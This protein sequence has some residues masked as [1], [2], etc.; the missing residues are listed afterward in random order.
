MNNRKKAG[1]CI[2]ALCL[3]LGLAM[4]G[5]TG[6][7]AEAPETAAAESE[8]LTEAS[9]TVTGKSEASADVVRVMVMNGPTGFGMAKLNH[10]NQAGESAQSYEITVESDASNAAAAMVSG[11]VDIAVI[12]TNLA[13]TLY[14]KTEGGVQAAAE[15]VRDNMYLLQAGGDPVE[16]VKDLEG[17]TVCAPAQHPTFIANYICQSGGLTPGENVTIDNTYAQP[18]DLRTALAAGEVELAVLPEP[19]VTIAMSQNE[20]IS[21]ALNL[22]E[23]WQEA[24]GQPM[25]LGCAAV[26]REFAEE[27]KEALDTFLAEYSESVTY[28]EEEPESASEMIAGARIFDKAPVALKAIPRCGVCFVTG[29]DMKAEMSSYLGILQELAPESIGG[30]LPGD[31]FYY[32]GK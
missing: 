3:S 17:K 6:V 24:S 29:E 19:M 28:L 20:D 22:G 27:H 9:E 14:T 32:I 26:R 13:A 21:V 7:L 12:P 15:V 18:A 5:A 25:V 10:D 2:A 31:D 23:L 11:S 16:S 4:S 1:N 30:A 8:A